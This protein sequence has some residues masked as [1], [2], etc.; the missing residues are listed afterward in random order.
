MIEEVMK[1]ALDGWFYTFN[2]EKQKTR[3]TRVPK[4]HIPEHRPHAPICLEAPGRGAKVW[5]PAEDNMLFEMF[6]KGFSF[7][8]MG[9]ALKI[10]QSLANN[11]FRELC[12]RRNVKPSRRNLTA[13]YDEAEEAALI[14]LKND[15]YTFRQIAEK[16][17]ITRNQVS[18]IWSRYKRRMQMMEQ[19]A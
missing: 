5:T 15:G 8:Q 3:A 11:R 12:I 14:K 18:G 6:E 2:A 7:K 16:M 1:A 10:S 13:K 9:T 19:A 17:N 4:D